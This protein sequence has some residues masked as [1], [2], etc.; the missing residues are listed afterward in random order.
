[1]HFL[2]TFLVYFLFT[3]SFGPFFSKFVLYCE[4]SVLFSR[5]KSFIFSSIVFFQLVI[6]PF[7]SILLGRFLK[8]FNVSLVIIIIKSKNVTYSQYFLLYTSMV[9]NIN[10]IKHFT[11]CIASK[12]RKKCELRQFPLTIKL[13]LN[14]IYKIAYQ[15]LQIPFR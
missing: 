12:M 2:G 9:L 1:M 5:I 7:S 15:G 13:K 8:E 10:I 3:L 4:Y 6:W 11:M 14:K